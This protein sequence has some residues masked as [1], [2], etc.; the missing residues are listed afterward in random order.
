VDSLDLVG[1]QHVPGLETED[2]AGV[3]RDVEQLAV[4]TEFDDH[5]ARALGDRPVEPIALA[6]FVALVFA[7][8][9]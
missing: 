2:L 7:L 5:V 8:R 3:R 6:Q 9:R 1:A 4:A